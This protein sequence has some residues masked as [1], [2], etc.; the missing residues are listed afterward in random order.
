MLR[1]T[2]RS[3]K[4]VL[5]SINSGILKY[6][7]LLHVGNACLCFLLVHL[8]QEILK[9]IMI[10]FFNLLTIFLLCG[11]SISQAQYKQVITNQT[12]LLNN[13]RNILPFKRLDERRIAVI[14]ADSVKYG[15]FIQQLQRYG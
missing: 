10:R 4:T 3:V 5:L 9:T 2:S 12:V 8:Q 11:Y 14:S 1:D 13:Q 7:E 6:T 15:P